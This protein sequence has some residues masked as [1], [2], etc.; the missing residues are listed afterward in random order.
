MF[1][2]ALGKEF[3]KPESVVGSKICKVLSYH[4]V[5]VVKQESVLLEHILHEESKDGNGIFKPKTL[6]QANML[7]NTL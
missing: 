2:N 1:H 7:L 5:E 3:I 6:G 4:C